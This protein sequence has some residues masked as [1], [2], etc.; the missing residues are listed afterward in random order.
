MWDEIDWLEI[1]N[2]MSVIECVLFF[3]VWENCCEE[4]NFKNDWLLMNIIWD[5]ICEFSDFNDDNKAK[6]NWRNF[7]W[8][9]SDFNDNNTIKKNWKNFDI[10]DVL[11]LCFVHWYYIFYNNQ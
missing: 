11:Q 1:D 8:E 10:V 7:V 9:F 5:F 3:Y 6:K 2:K 4:D